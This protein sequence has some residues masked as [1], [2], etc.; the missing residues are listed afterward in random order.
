L[1]TAL[2]R[3][4]KSPRKRVP[5]SRP[6]VSSAKISGALQRFLDVVGQQARREPFGH[7]RLAD[8]RLADEHRVVLAA[9]AQHSMVRCSSSVRPMSGSS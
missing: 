5:A 6:A 4:S 3:S 2:K 9:P 7:R 8:A 1:I